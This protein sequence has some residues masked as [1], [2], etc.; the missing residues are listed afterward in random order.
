MTGPHPARMPKKTAKPAPRPVAA[1]NENTAQLLVRV[2][3]ELVEQLDAWVAKL[4]ASATGPRWT[5][6]D[7][8]RAVLKRAVAE[9]GERGEA[10]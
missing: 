10:P 2:A 7:V 6:S 1:D 9:K 5:R 3:P 8:A 4:N